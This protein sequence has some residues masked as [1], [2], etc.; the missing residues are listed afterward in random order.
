M[1]QIYL[2]NHQ[3]SIHTC[4]KTQSDQKQLVHVQQ[5]PFDFRAITTFEVLDLFH[6]HERS[7]V[8]QSLMMQRNPTE[9]I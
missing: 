6:D 4:S 8:F 2:Q 7:T 1:F 9:Q 3:T 5:C